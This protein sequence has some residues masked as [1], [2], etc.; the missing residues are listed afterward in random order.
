MPRLILPIYVLLCLGCSQDYE[1]LSQEVQRLRLAF[2]LVRYQQDVKQA[3]TIEEITSV[4]EK[5]ERL[6]LSLK[7]HLA[8]VLVSVYSESLAQTYQT[9]EQARQEFNRCTQAVE[10]AAKM[11]EPKKRAYEQAQEASDQA[12]EPFLYIRK[13]D[14]GGRSI[15]LKKRPPPRTHEEAKKREEEEKRWN[16]AARIAKKAK[17]EYRR[18]EEEYIQ[19]RKAEED[20]EVKYIQSVLHAWDW[21]DLYVDRLVQD[22]DA[23]E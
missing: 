8:P 14:G 11:I 12:G 16:E 3:S 13:R 19:A 21:L 15:A 6:A 18:S 5:G 23:R 20:A 9:V 1:R 22:E 4:Y 10:Q 7:P 2:S 17:K